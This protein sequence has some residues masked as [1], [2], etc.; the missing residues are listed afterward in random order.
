MSGFSAQL[1]EASSGIRERIG[2]LAFVRELADGSLSRERFGYYLAQDAHYLRDYARALAALAALA[3]TPQAQVFWGKAGTEAI[4]VE[5]LLHASH[6]D[7][8]TGPAPSPT[9]V[10]Y[11]SFLL[12]EATRGDYASLAAAVLPCFVVYADVGARLAAAARAQL[13]G[14]DLSAHP[15]GDWIA[16]YENPAFA[17]SA[18]QASEL[19]DE[20]AAGAAAAGRERMTGAYLTATRCE[21]MFWDAAYRLESWPA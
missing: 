13:P 11:T 7:V 20:A 19:V 4:E 18:R 12:A 14:G 6:V 5:L 2:Q 1:W 16:T 17:G 15:Y 8:L 9:C 21:W 10:L 3:P